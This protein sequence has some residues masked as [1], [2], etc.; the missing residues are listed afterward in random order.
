MNV[1]G[2]ISMGP[3]SFEFPVHLPDAT[4]VSSFATVK[5]ILELWAYEGIGSS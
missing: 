3:F 2:P 5:K 4:R 1:K